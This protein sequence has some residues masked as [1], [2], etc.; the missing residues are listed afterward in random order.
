MKKGCLLKGLAGGLVLVV[1]AVGWKWMKERSP[2]DTE[3]GRGDARPIPV[4][5]A[6]IRR[7]MIDE[8]RVFSGSLEA[9]AQM[10]ISPNVSGRV[11]RIHADLGDPVTRGQV[12][13]ELDAEEFEQALARARAERAVAEAQ[14]NEAE[15]RLEIAQRER[16]RIQELRERGISSESALDEARA[17]YL[18]RTSALEVAKA[19]VSARESAVETAQIQLRDTRIR[20][21]WSEGDDSRVVAQRMVDEGDTVSANTPVFTVIELQPVRAVVFVPERD[22][23]RLST[24]QRVEL[25]TDA[26]PGRVFEGVIQRISP[27][28][29]A[30]SRQ[31][32]VEI[33]T[34]NQDLALKP[35][36]FIRATVTLDHVEGATLV[37]ADAITRRGNT[38]GVFLVE[39]NSETARWLEVTPG[40]REGDWVQILDQELE[41]KVVTLGQ[42]LLDDGS[43]LIL[44]EE[45]SAEDDPS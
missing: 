42:Q 9:S 41:G 38:Q 29:Q 26:W 14:R 27:V 25:T 34:D 5:V 12:L 32:R 16:D 11:E 17:G 45:E 37:P 22:Y 36:L 30:D 19:T 21:V 35:G 15:N 13:V 3:F 18:I 43:K 20:A 24:G 6:S 44:P 31:A 4:E 23:S 10:R 2:G 8:K 1:I 39:E 28:F 7:G 33:Q 40:I